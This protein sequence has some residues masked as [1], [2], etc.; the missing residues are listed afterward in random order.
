MPLSSALL[1]TKIIGKEAA[2]DVVAFLKTKELRTAES[3]V[4][5]GSDCSR[6]FMRL[7]SSAISIA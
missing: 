4:I 7:M 3:R 2:S 1:P 5:A 6:S